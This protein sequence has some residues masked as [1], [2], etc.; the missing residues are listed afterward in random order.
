MKINPTTAAI[1]AVA[2]IAAASGQELTV[3][4]KASNVAPAEG[5]VQDANTNFRLKEYPV[6]VSLSTA[7]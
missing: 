2:S 7:T 4:S 5:N 3:E 6:N 1:V